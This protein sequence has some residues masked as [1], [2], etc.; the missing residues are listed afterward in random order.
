MHGQCFGVLLSA[1]AVIRAFCG[2]WTFKSPPKHCQASP[3]FCGASDALAAC[4]TVVV[5]RKLGS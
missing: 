5:K 3:Q 2:F 4:L 1:N